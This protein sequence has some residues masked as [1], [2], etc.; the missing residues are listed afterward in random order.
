MAKQYSALFALNRGLVSRYGVA[1][2]DIKRIALAAQEMTNW[3]PRVLGN[4]SL[5]VGRKYIGATYTSA[6]ARL[7]PFI[8]ATD[9]TALV[10]LTASIARIWINDTLLTRPSVSSAVTN[11]TFDANLGSW[12]DDDEGSAASTWASPG[13]M[14][15]VGT[16]SSRA[17][18]T[19]QVTVAA[20]DQGVEHALRVVIARGPVSIRVGSTS[21]G[22]EY[23]AEAVLQEGTHSLSFTPTGNFYV[24]FLSLQIP[25]VWVDSCTV[26]AAGVVT[27]PTPW[28]AASLSKV[29]Y[30]QSADVM[31][32]GCPGYQQRRIVRRGTRPGARSWS[33]DLYV[34]PDGPFAVQN[35]TTTTIATSAI[36]GNV[37]LTA[38]KPTFR[39]TDVGGL[40]SITSVGQ[41]V[42]ATASASAS[43]TSS[44]RVTGIGAE[45]AIAIEITGDA[46]ASTVTLQRSYDNTT[47]ADTTSTW[48]ADT[49]TSYNDTLDNQ[50]VYYRLMLTTR[51]APD[52]VTMTLRYGSGSIRGIVRVTGYSTQVSVTAEV[53]VAMGGTAASTVWQ[54]GQWSDR[55]GWPTA[56]R[57]QEGR[58]WW[59]G[60]NG[61]WGSV[62]DAYDSFDETTVGES[63][64]I[65]RTIGSGPVDTINWLVGLQRLLVGAQG[66]EYS[67]KSSS[68]DE[69]LS[70]TNFNLK[71]C[72]T[73]GSGDVEALK[74]DQNCVFV[75]RSKIKVFE[76]SFD[77][78]AYDYQAQD[79][80]SLVPELGKPGIVRMDIQRQPDTRLHCVRSDGTA[81]VMVRDKLE[82]VTA[83]VEVSGVGL[84]EDVVVLPALAGNVDD[85]VYYVVTYTIG[86]ATVRY[87]E[88]WA[89]EV[90]CRGDQRYCYLA[91]CYVTTTGRTIT[92]LSYLEGQQVVVWADGYDV[93]T[94]DDFTLKYTVSGG[95]IVLDQNYTT[96]IVGLPYAARFQS[97]K[98]GEAQGSPL[99][100]QKRVDHLGLILADTHP[101]GLRYGPDFTYLDTRPQIEAGTGVGTGVTTDYD[102]NL[103]EFPGQWT[104]DAR[105]CLLA[106][107]PRP[108]TVMAA[109]M[110]LQVN[111]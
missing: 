104:T 4:M 55:N 22:D 100:V 20:G 97:T 76:L 69:P 56:V 89:Q 110:I 48:T 47:W 29:R 83:W 1:R 61:I 14:Q 85:Q 86:G 30:D 28:P 70:P 94:N 73:Q 46:T 95:Q 36:T 9:D 53:V 90:D 78:R 37:T 19:Q 43:P 77:V 24:Q 62:S 65:N 63:G 51:V 7:L 82:D 96:V 44:V 41:T 13:Y 15:L 26:E 3:M 106:Q 79:L 103:I 71:T 45:R 102:E 50:I 21:G 72:S 5:R 80:T 93:G 74:M 105:I 33:V 64:P 32:L 39:S 101:Q 42:T 75:N 8:F 59:T 18:R 49:T 54:R 81:I 67:A 6:A 107:A 91:D 111:Q 40:Y 92:G 58:L 34:A 66:A 109:T 84:I 27:L 108:A 99:N 38:S 88:K 16:G 60:A 68:L 10:E 52:S 25:L 11:G 23:I 57:F 2:A 12:T 35:T 87:I 17:I 98:L 31:Y